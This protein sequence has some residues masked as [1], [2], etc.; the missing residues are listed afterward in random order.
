VGNASRTLCA[1]PGPPPGGKG[2]DDID[3]PTA[4]GRPRTLNPGHGAPPRSRGGGAL[5]LP[6]F[7]A[8]SE[9]EADGTLREAIFTV[10]EEIRGGDPPGGVPIAADD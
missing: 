9:P 7:A 8:A 1:A 10:R 4:Y 3:T 2:A 6:A 5:A